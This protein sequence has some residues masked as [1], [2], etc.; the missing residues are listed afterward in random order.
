MLRQAPHCMPDG[1]MPCTY[2][3]R[4]DL[5]CYDLVKEIQSLDKLPVSSKYSFYPDYTPTY[6]NEKFPDIHGIHCSFYAWLAYTI[7]KKIIS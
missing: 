3:K 5:S 1:S 7:S 4:Q 2:S 6:S